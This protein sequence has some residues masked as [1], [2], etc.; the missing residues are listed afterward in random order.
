[1]FIAALFDVHQGMPG[2]PDLYSF[3]VITVPASETVSDIHDRMPAILQTADEITDWLQ[4][5]NPKRA[6]ACLRS[7]TD[8]CFYA[9]SSHV[10][11]T[12]NNDKLC[13]QPVKLE[14]SALPTAAVTL[15]KWLPAASSKLTA[16]ASASASAASSAS[17]PRYQQ[18]PKPPPPSPKRRQPPPLRDTGLTRWIRASRVKSETEASSK[19]EAEEETKPA[20][21]KPRLE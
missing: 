2:E 12:R 7:V 8:I 21:K 16:A 15:D 10:N 19:A 4:S 11:S 20:V 6:L 9:V 3:T 13:L 14:S 17:P 18:N 1:M 5:D